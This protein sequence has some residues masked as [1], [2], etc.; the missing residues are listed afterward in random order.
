M[1]INGFELFLVYALLEYNV[2]CLMLTMRALIKLFGRFGQ[3]FL[4]CHTKKRQLFY[5]WCTVLKLNQPN[6]N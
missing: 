4:S 2:V 3:C 6:K 1:E 5:L